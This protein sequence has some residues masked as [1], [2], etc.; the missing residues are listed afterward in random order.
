MGFGSGQLL[1]AIARESVP[2]ATTG[3]FPVARGRAAGTLACFVAGG[4]VDSTRGEHRY[5]TVG[6]C[7]TGHLP[8]HATDDAGN[9]MNLAH[10]GAVN[11]P[12]AQARGL[13]VARNDKAPASGRWTAA[14]LSPSTA[15]GASSDADVTQC[16][17]APLPAR[18]AA[19]V[20]WGE[21]R[22]A[23]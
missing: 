21:V 7:A 15:A 12:I 5:E 6:R 2:N 23:V 3:G 14:R 10:G 16:T 18:T 22:G 1:R 11:Y 13:R 8:W 17:R 9:G 20:R 4:L 19:T